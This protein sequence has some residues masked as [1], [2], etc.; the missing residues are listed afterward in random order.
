V[1]IRQKDM[2]SSSSDAYYTANNTEEATDTHLIISSQID[3][4]GTGAPTYRHAY[5]CSSSNY[6]SSYILHAL[7]SGSRTT[8]GIRISGTYICIN[9]CNC[10][11]YSHVVHV[12]RS[13]CSCS[14]CCSY[15][16]Y[17]QNTIVVIHKNKIL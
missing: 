1:P 9:C 15:N 6:R 2:Q 7:L 14:N 12:F 10:K 11:G 13:S 8:T 4:S 16:S 17:I 5:T 3:L